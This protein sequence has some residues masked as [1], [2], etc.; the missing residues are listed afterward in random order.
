MNRIENFVARIK[1][2]YKA[3]IQTIY[4]ISG[5]SSVGKDGLWKYIKKMKL[6]KK[7]NIH[8]CISTTTRYPRV[9]ETCGKDY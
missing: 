7:Y 1:K 3:S 8:H 5:P 6:H 9:N 2:N 4:F